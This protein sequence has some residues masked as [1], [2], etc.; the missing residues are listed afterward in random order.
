ML[1]RFAGSR[2]EMVAAGVV[3]ID[4][5]TEVR[6]AVDAVAARCGRRQLESAYGIRLPPPPGAAGG[7]PP[8]PPRA[9]QLLAALAAARGWAAGGGLPD[10]ARAGRAILKDYTAGRLVHCQLPPGSDPPGWAPE[11]A[12]EKGGGIEQQP[13]LRP[14][15]PPGGAGAAGA[16]AKQRAA[17]GEGAEEEVS[18][19]DGRRR[20]A[21]AAEAAAAAAGGVE[22]FEDGGGLLL[23]P[24]DLELLD[25]LSLGQDGTGAPGA[26]A[27]AAKGARKPRPA[28]PEYKLHNKKGSGRA[29]GARGAVQD[30]GGYD[31]AA[32]AV[33]KKG[34]LLRVAGYQ[35]TE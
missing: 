13:L 2:A 27:A 5:L 20:A 12:P 14:A 11:V 22:D 28:R 19:E 31:G 33:G 9:P 4:R 34:G 24:A 29:K 3:P 30:G 26:A 32:M 23:D 35:A 16:D 21:A 17:A 1:P 25:E 6:S 18:E 7:G 15:E 8:P 10:E